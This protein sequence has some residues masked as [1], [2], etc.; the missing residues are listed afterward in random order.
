M[1]FVFHLMKLIV[2]I[3]KVLKI[4]VKSQSMITMKSAIKHLISMVSK[5]GIFFF[6]FFFFFGG[7]G[8]WE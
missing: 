7:V 6:F 3:I 5:F 4:Y 1:L 8:G 2:N